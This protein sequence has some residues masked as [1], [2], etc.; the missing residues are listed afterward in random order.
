[1]YLVLTPQTTLWSA[2]KKVTF[3]EYA[4]LLDD[5]EKK[6]KSMGIL[7]SSKSK[8]LVANN[9]GS[10]NSASQSSNKGKGKKK[11]WKNKRS[12]DAKNRTA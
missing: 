4:K 2:Y 8:A 6:L 10:P 3:D 5:E 1:M 11:K 7:N 12:E 9:E